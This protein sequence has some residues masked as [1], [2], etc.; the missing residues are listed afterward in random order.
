[1]NFI[2]KPFPGD[3][4]DIIYRSHFFSVKISLVRFLNKKEY[5]NNNKAIPKFQGSAQTLEIVLIVILLQTL[6]LQSS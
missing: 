2:G 4:I 6:K 5:G 3:I 1:M